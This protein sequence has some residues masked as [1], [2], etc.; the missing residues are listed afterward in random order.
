M[1]GQTEQPV[2][3]P[4]CPG[5]QWQAWAVVEAIELVLLSAGHDVQAAPALAY[6]PYGH[7]EHTPLFM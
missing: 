1:A 3:S 7:I 6:V 5:L 4:T 2:E